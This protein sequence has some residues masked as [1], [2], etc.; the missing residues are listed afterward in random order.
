MKLLQIKVKPNARTSELSEMPDG[1][2]LAQIKSPPVDGKA[3][4]ELIALVA[5]HFD[6][7]KSQ[8]TVKSGASGRMKLIKIDDA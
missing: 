3:N 8:I 2:W 1:T 7:R 5:K 6:R 4:E